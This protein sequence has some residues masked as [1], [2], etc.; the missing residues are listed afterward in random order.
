MQ[1]YEAM[2]LKQD[3]K[4]L[5]DDITTNGCIHKFTADSEKV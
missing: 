2:R 1:F 4:I 5:E 3:N